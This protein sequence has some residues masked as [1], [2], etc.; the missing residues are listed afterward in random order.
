[1]SKVLFAFALV[2]CFFLL[3]IRRP[4]RSTLCQTLFPYTTLFRSLLRFGGRRRRESGRPVRIPGV[5][6][7]SEEHTSELQSPDTI[8]YAVFCLKKKSGIVRPARQMRRLSVPRCLLRLFCM[9][10]TYVTVIFFFNDTAT[11]EIYTVSDTLSLH[12]ALPIWSARTRPWSRPRPPMA[13]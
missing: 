11:T 2:F 9:G 3:M 8:S 5:R 7:R 1:M 12:D 4:P 6:G 10:L 13:A